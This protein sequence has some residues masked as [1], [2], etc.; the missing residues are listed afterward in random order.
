MAAFYFGMK[1]VG[2]TVTPQ[3]AEAYP[4]WNPLPYYIQQRYEANP[5]QGQEA[6]LLLAL[7]RS[8]GVRFQLGPNNE[9]ERSCPVQNERALVNKLPYDIR[10]H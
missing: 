3:K 7:K 10:Q 8:F 5:V 2:H 4:D 6:Y 1:L 9:G